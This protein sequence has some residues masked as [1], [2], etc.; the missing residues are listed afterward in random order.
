MAAQTFMGVFHRVLEGGKW[1][2]LSTA[3]SKCYQLIVDLAT[4][5]FGSGEIIYEL[6]A[7]RFGGVSRDSLLRPVGLTLKNR[8]RK[9]WLLAG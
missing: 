3:E 4:H 8:P 2:F 7:I 5:R 9:R 1:S 6:I